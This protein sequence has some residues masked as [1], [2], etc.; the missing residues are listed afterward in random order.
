MP[1]ATPIEPEPA[2]EDPPPSPA[3]ETAEAFDDEPAFPPEVLEA[4][5]RDPLAFCEFVLR[6]E[7]GDPIKNAPHHREI[8]DRL[9]DPDNARCVILAFAESGKTTSVS[10]GR[11]LWELGHNPN[12]RVGILGD[13]TGK[14]AE[15]VA[16]LARYVNESEELR[17]VFPH[18][19]QARRDVDPLRNLK[20]RPVKWAMASFTVER[21]SRSRDPSVRAT[22]AG[23][24]AQGVRFDLLIV[25]D[26]VTWETSL[27]DKRRKKLSK[28]FKN[29]ISGR[30]TPQS[31]VW[32]LNT[33][34][35]PRDLPHEF[36]KDRGYKLF[37]YPARDP[38]TKLSN[39]A[40]KWDVAALAKRINDLGGE[41][42]V[43]VARQ[44]DAIAKDENAEQFREEWIEIALKAGAGLST[45]ARWVQPPELPADAFLVT[46]VDIG[47]GKTERAAETVLFT[48]LVFPSGWAEWGYLPGT[49]QVLCIEAGRWTGPEILERVYDAHERFGSIVYVESNAAQVWITQ[50][51]LTGEQGKKRPPPP[52]VPFETRANKWSPVFGVA[53]IGIDMSQGRAIVPA[54]DDGR[55]VDDEIAKW[56]AELR[57]FSPDAHTGD[58]HMAGWI[59]REGARKHANDMGGT[60]DVLGG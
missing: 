6:D 23:K 26:L 11:V 55:V 57:A 17:A 13:T 39:W 36:A 25:D 41:G 35:H 40:G 53:S 5:R 7:N 52:V 21:S 58:R 9:S 50:F 38:I 24:P 28:W 15:I 48:I 12:L 45:M 31:R 49:Y 22:G 46:G 27:T 54:N 20:G 44:V 16:V 56:L 42:S 4:A 1:V 43:E 29:A 10:I 3:N 14:V 2:E 51:K 34:Y 19:R 33:A 37:R 47:L 8:H 30:L 18:L 32:F 60:V 59:A